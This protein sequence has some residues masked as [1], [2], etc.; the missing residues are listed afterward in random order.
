[1]NDSNG[2]NRRRFLEMVVLGGTATL[3]ACAAPAAPTPTQAPA[4]KPTTA[5]A[6]A[7]SAAPAGAPSPSPAAAASPAALASPSVAPAV[8]PTAAA[9]V[10][11]VAGAWVQINGSMVP[12]WIA[13]DLGLYE[14]YGLKATMS[15]VQGSPTG[16]AALL[17]GSLHVVQ[18]AGAA[19]VNA[20]ASNAP[21][22]MI[23]GFV[24]RAV[25]KV[26]SDPSI[27]SL[28]DF[29]GKSLDI[30]A[31][32]GAGDFIMRRVLTDAGVDLNK[33]TL[34][35]SRDVQAQIAAYQGKLIQGALVTPPDNVRFQ[36]IG[37]KVLLD[38]ATLNIPFQS[39][40]V[41]TTRQLIQDRRPAI[42]AFLKGEIEAI[43]I[44]KTNREQA[45]AVLKKY[46]NSDDQ[47]VIAASYE[48]YAPVFEDIPYPS[49]E[50]LQE[51]LNENKDTEHKPEQ[52]MDTTLIKE[53]EDTG[54]FKSL[55]IA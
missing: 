37:A 40:G 48:A 2:V 27:S 55:G 20:V 12:A 22:A 21:V 8:K 54:F 47:T 49:R 43:H 9:S 33:V 10:G 51:L 39:V 44:F 6:A 18:M 50:G 24:N 1:M 16:L 29:E 4:A 28:K 15:S 52:M 35:P 31:Q 41:A 25:F 42:L 3:A 46:L 26:M 32:G 53:L 45:E 5:P 36:Q 38:T 23:A 13:T 30:G 14:K 17:G 19:V 34:L 7:P 11:E